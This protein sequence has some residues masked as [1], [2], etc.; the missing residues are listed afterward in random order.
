MHYANMPRS[1]EC[2]A[3]LDPS[4]EVY[5]GEFLH[6]LDVCCFD[7]LLIVEE[8]PGQ[9]FLLCE[10]LADEGHIVSVGICQH[11]GRILPKMLLEGTESYPA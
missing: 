7:H 10:L 11:V 2:C 9:V 6:L 3:R 1:L 4:K 5:I 8:H